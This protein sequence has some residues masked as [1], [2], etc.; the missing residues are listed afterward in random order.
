MLSFERKYRVRGRTLIGGDLFD[1]WVGPFFVGF[2]GVTTIFFSRHVAVVPAQHVADPC[3]VSEEHGRGG[4]PAGVAHG[5]RQAV[6]LVA[7]HYYVPRF[8][9]YE[10]RAVTELLAETLATRIAALES[11]AQAQAPASARTPAR[12]GR[13]PAPGSPR[14]SARRSAGSPPGAGGPPRA[15]NSSR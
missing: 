1:F 4:D 13:A 11:F 15:S 12:P 2:F 6:G 7:C 3:P 9:H 10:M 5:R 14:G 8:V